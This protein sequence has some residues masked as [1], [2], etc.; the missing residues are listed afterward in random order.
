MKL[1]K[2]AYGILTLAVLTFLNPN[3]NAF[4]FFPDFIGAFIIAAVLSRASD[5]VPFFKEAQ[6]GFTRVGVLSLIRLPAAL[7]MYANLHTGM[8]IVPLFTLVFCTLEL[9]LLY[10][11]IANL[12]RGLVYL[13]ERGSAV[14]IVKPIKLF[15]RTVGIE[16]VKNLSLVFFGVRAVF[17]FLPQLCHLT[18]YSQR[19]TYVARRIYAP[20]E[21]SMLLFL[22]FFGIVWAV[23][24]LS[25]L[26]AVRLRGGVADGIIAMAGEERLAEISRSASAKSH[27]RSLNLLWLAALF[28]LDIALDTTGG[29]NVLPRFIFAILLLL[30]VW[31]FFTRGALRLSA[32]LSAICFSLVS[33]AVLLLCTEFSEVYSTQD[34]ATNTVAQGEY[35]LIEILSGA[36]LLLYLLLVGLTTAGLVLGVKRHTGLSPDGEGYSKSARAHHA[37]LIKLVVGFSAWLG[38]V[39]ILKF[40][41]I[42]LNA[43]PQRMEAK[44]GYTVYAARLPWLGT[45]TFILS[46]VLVLYAF[47]LSST[48]KDEVRMKYGLPKKGE[49]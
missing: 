39:G 7:V 12:Y 23:I 38:A 29:F 36:E 17:N 28:N 24:T 45:A 21:I 18:F 2:S 27:V 19:T 14:G 1:N 40:V 33:L 46:L 48:L 42:I 8:D 49:E 6:D 15:G 11:A 30:A 41:N 37:G 13:G 32:L 22:L 34:L 44:E 25:L 16:W 4:D 5:V 20:I 3:F 35:L 26:R 43:F 10:P 9:I 31:S 47:Y